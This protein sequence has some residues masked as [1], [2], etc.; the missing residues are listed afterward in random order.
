MFFFCF[1]FFFLFQFSPRGAVELLVWESTI[2]AWFSLAPNRP[3]KTKRKFFFFFFF[4][5]DEI[6]TSERKLLTRELSVSPRA[7]G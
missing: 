1:L 7:R 2:C 5:K 6:I 4:L 3:S